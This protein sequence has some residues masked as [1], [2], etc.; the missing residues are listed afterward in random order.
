MRSYSRLIA[1]DS[2][3][4]NIKADMVSNDLDTLDTDT[5]LHI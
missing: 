5:L 2:K 3:I 1:S 4:T